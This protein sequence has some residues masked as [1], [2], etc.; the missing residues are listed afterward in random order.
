MADY[1]LNIEVTIISTILS[2]LEN[3]GE[4]TGIDNRI[5]EI[6]IDL[7]EYPTL[8]VCGRFFY[9]TFRGKQIT[10]KEFAYFIYKKIIRYCIPR[11]KLEQAKVKFYETGDE[12]YITALQDQARNLFVKSMEERGAHLGEPGLVN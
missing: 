9:L 2:E 5:C 4:Y 11:T 8:N 10:E 12:S 3:A 6:T 1:Q 7:P